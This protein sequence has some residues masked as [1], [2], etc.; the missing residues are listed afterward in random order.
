MEHKHLLSKASE[1][2]RPRRT[3][4]ADER[5]VLQEPRPSLRYIHISTCIPRRPRNS[6]L[7]QA[8]Q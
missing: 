2:K 1:N 4:H 3:K 6:D 5:I 7:A 8:R